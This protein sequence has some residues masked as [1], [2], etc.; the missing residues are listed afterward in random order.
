[1][2]II[3]NLQYSA[4]LSFATTNAKKEAIASH[5]HS[6]YTGHCVQGITGDV[7]SADLSSCAEQDW[8]IVS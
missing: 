5:T 3:G 4:H 8:K 2:S 6:N 1:M 7:I